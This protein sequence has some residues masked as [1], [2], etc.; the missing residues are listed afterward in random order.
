VILNLSTL[1]TELGALIKSTAITND[2]KD[3]WLNLA[4]D[5]VATAMDAEH[6][7]HRISFTSVADTR[8]YY[9]DFEFNKILSIRDTTNN[10]DLMP[11]TEGQ[12]E[13][14]DPDFSYSGTPDSYSLTGLSMVA[15]QPTSAS[16]VT[17][18][19]SSASDTSQKVRVNGFDANGTAIT[20]LIS[21]NG[22]TN[23]VGSTSFTEIKQVL[24]DTTTAGNVTVTTNSGVVTVV[25]IPSFSLAREYQPINLY[26]VPSGANVYVVRGMQKARPMVNAEDIP[27]L[28]QSW[29][30]LVLVG[31]AIRGHID[32]FRPTLALNLKAQLWEPKVKQLRGE[33]GNK[34]GKFSPVIGEGSSIIFGGRLPSN[35]P[36]E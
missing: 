8:T 16:V 4:Q 12:L 20:E 17:I 14:N 28:P 19:S 33:M 29:H 36:L 26:P 34:R 27:D 11:L 23:A 32:R 7:T 35:Y 3:R 6:L 31:A 30:E 9:L 10:W 2:R 13:E 18:V 5:D 15:A 22:T 1:R 25:R 21:L 24:K